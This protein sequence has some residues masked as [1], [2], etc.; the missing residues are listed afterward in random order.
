MTD[1]GA[2][3]R[4]LF[5]PD[6]PR[7]G[8]QRRL[9][10]LFAAARIESAALD[11]RLLLC[12][13][14]GIDH[15]ALVRDP[16]LPLG[17]GAE[18]LAGF[19]AR[20]L[21][22]EPVSRILGQR[23]FWGLPFK[24]SPAVLDPRADTE[25]LVEAVLAAFAAR[26]RE[27]LR[28]LD[29]GTGSGAILA[30]LLTELPSASGVGLDNSFAACRIARENFERLGLAG[31]G[32]VVQGSWAGALRGPFDIIVSN[33]PYISAEDL[34]LLARDVRDYDPTAALDGGHDGLEPY[35]LI[36]PSLPPLLAPGGFV[37]FEIGAT[38]GEPVSALLWAAGL[39]APGVKTDLA[40]HDRVVFAANSKHPEDHSRECGA[41]DSRIG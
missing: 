11:A 38:Q 15:A 21:R 16:G 39:G 29:L 10:D 14:L 2:G 41:R 13:A 23:E 31:R 9:H 33:P 32:H 24:I 3:H 37:A 35:R 25:I 1:P 20:R 28:V 12:A 5:P 18:R 30:A 4:L 27:P 40:G 7:S 6:L 17:P 34:E 36:I 22:H 8:A 19:V 26:R